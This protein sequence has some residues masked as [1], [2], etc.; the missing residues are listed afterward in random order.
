MEGR[1]GVVEE[2]KRT[3]HSEVS[4]QSY[5]SDLTDDTSLTR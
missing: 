2:K 3:M 1:A 5:I 4:K